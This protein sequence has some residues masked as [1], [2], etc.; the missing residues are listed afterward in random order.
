[1]WQSDYY[2]SVAV[3]G[4]DDRK[5]GH[6]T[7]KNSSKIVLDINLSLICKKN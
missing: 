2:K 5:K 7:P 3:V 4:Y 1:M 6:I